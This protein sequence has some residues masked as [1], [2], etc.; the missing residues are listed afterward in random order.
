MALLLLLIILFDAGIA[1]SSSLPFAFE[2]LIQKS[3]QDRP[4]ETNNP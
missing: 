3:S 2:V 4:T 1:K